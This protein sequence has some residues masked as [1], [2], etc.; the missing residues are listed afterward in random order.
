MSEL[1][2]HAIK[3]IQGFIEVHQSYTCI[4][5]VIVGVVITVT[6]IHEKMLVC[7][8]ISPFGWLFSDLTIG[9][10]CACGCFFCQSLSCGIVYL[11]ICIPCTV[12]FYT[13]DTV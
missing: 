6:D 4:I 2:D 7:G 10:Y 5:I 1:P 9:S 8:S 12:V 3:T 13:G 11:Y